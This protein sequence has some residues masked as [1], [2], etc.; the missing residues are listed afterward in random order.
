MSAPDEGAPSLQLLPHGKIKPTPWHTPY[1]V[2]T[3]DAYPEQTTSMKST[4]LHI[5]QRGNTLWNHRM[6]RF[7][8]PYFLKNKILLYVFLYFFIF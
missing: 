2:Y 3:V 6:A 1:D 5:D 8:F 4:W 7:S